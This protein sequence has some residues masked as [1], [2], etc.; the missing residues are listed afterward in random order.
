MPMLEMLKPL[1]WG[2]DGWGDELASGAMVT[3]SLAISSYLFGLVIGMFGAWAKIGGPR[4]VRI[5]GDVYTTVVRGVPELLVI[6]LL[7]FGSANLLG[8][9]A[10]LFGYKGFVSLPEFFVGTLAVGFIS[11]AYSIEV[12]RGAIQ[13]LPKGQIEAAKAVGMSPL[14]VFRRIMLP[15]LLRYALPGL[16]N[17]WQLCLKDTSLVSVTGLY[18]LMRTAHVAGGSTR[19]YFPFLLAAAALFLLFSTGSSHLFRRGE[20]WANRG[21]RRA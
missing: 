12:F 9:I 11:G 10:H 6:Y 19:D 4:W 7:F 14:L 21:V 16:G 17:V 3:L 15:Q 1:A 13:A 5:A 8:R 20:R 18:E 2:P